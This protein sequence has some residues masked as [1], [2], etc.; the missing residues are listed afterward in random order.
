M[1]LA[2]YFDT[3]PDKSGTELR[4]AT[5]LNP[6]DDDPI[7]PG[8]YL[9]TEYFCTDLSCHCN[10][11]LIKVMRFESRK[12]PPEDVA[13]ISYCWDLDGDEGWSVVNQDYSEPM[14]DPMNRQAPY[15]EDLLEFWTNMIEN[16]PA[17]LDRIQRHYDEIRDELGSCGD[18]QFADHELPHSSGP[19]QRLPLSK[20]QRRARQQRL[21]KALKKR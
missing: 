17:Y 3:F 10:R 2:S 1:F 15:A 13:T 21:K 5:F 20:K 9:F 18:H 4:T 6:A 16:D 8:T 7:P 11:V 19:K 14:L 12:S